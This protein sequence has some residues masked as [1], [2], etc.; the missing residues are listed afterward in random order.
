MEEE[1]G[2]HTWVLVGA[3]VAAEMEEKHK[4]ATDCTQIHVDN[5]TDK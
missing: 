1:R 4:A 3:S 2:K 5:V